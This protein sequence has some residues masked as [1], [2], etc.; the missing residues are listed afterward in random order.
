MQRS[1]NVILSGLVGLMM[2][3]MAACGTG[4]GAGPTAPSTSSAPQKATADKQVFNFPEGSIADLGTF[5]PAQATTQTSLD[6]IL[7]A[8]TGLIYLD[9]NNQIHS[10]MASSWSVASDGIT[11]TFHLK[12][13][14]KFSDGTPL[15]SKDVVYSIDRALQPRLNSPASPSYLGLIKDSNKLL[16][17]KVKTIIGDSLMTPDDNTVVI[18]ANA[19]SAYFLDTLTYSTSYV[20]EKSLID[21]YGDIKWTDHLTE[22][23]GDGPFMVQ[24]F[25]HG[26]RIVFVPNPNYYGP[27]PQ[28]QKVIFTF[29]KDSDTEYKD[30]QNGQLDQSPVPSAELDRVRTSPEYHKI[31]ILSIFYYGMNFLSKPFDNIH[32]RQAF[33]LA[34]NKDAIVKAAWHDVEIPTNHI[35]PQGM[36]GYDP[37]LKGPDGT[38]S[39]RGNPNMARQLLQQGLQEAGYAN[40]AALPPISIKYQSGSTEG[41]NE[42]AAAVQQWQ[43]VLGISVKA[44]PE[45]FEKLSLEEPQTVG[46][47]SLQMFDSGWGDDYPDPQDFLTLQFSKGSPNNSTNIGQNSSSDAAQQVQMQQLMT[48]ADT[49]KD[50]AARIKAYQQ[51]EQVLVNDVAWLPIYQLA[52]S[53]VLKSYVIGRVFNSSD[54]TPPDDWGVVYIA[55]H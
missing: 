46:N 30:Y 8:F 38:T 21:K 23:G 54:L 22:G 40:V 2:V 49:M 52:R 37:D 41:A 32:I 43:T 13:G 11:W 34:L 26:Q 10:Q 53:R 1:R 44:L 3:F 25:T 50:P 12:P 24:E 36:P 42:I 33:E 29:V 39:T 7:M 17:G 51:A 16:G 18:V 6:A 20:V 4:Q 55:A 35:V 14:L 47:G 9:D 48:Q 19:P 15:T 27:K 45:D 31:P 5:D 28:L